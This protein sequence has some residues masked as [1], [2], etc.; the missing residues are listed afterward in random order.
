MRIKHLTFA[1]SRAYLQALIPSFLPPARFGTEN[2]VGPSIYGSLTFTYAASTIPTRALASG[3]AASSINLVK[4]ALG[5]NY[6]F[7]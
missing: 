6:S 1:V 4:R 5:F 2:L 3:L 7:D